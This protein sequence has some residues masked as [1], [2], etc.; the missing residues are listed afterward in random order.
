MKLCRIGMWWILVVTLAS[1]AWAADE[2]SPMRKATKATKATWPIKWYI[3]PG[4]GPVVGN[5]NGWFVTPAT[6]LRTGRGSRS[7]P[8][9]E[10]IMLVRRCLICVVATGCLL[11]GGAGLAAEPDA[12]LPPIQELKTPRP[13][14]N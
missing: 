13:T 6:F 11:A 7:H 3:P 9:K 10:R 8:A 12:K 5:Q 14:P 4:E 2:A 1:A